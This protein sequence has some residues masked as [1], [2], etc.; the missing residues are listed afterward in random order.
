MSVIT[1]E[2]K[3]PEMKL[4]FDYVTRHSYISIIFSKVRNCI[5]GTMI[6][7]T[8]LHV[9]G[10]LDRLEMELNHL[11]SQDGIKWKHALNI[12]RKFFQSKTKMFCVLLYVLTYWLP[13]SG[14]PSLSSSGSRSS[15]IPS[16]SSSGLDF[17]D[18]I[19]FHMR[20]NSNSVCIKSN[21]SRLSRQHHQLRQHPC[22]GSREKRK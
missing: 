6:L 8:A 12:P 18:F 10:S 1:K 11:D 22:H 15:G 9:Q 14:I 13:M 21:K 20:F 16:L 2:W 3:F 19:H 4:I 5:L 17:K 7:L